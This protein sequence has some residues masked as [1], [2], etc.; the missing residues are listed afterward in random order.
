MQWVCFTDLPLLTLSFA[1]FVFY[2]LASRFLASH[3]CTHMY[4]LIMKV[5]VGIC[6]TLC[7]SNHLYLCTLLSSIFCVFV[8]LSLTMQ[9][10]IIVK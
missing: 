10:V 8:D 7:P 1:L 5:C 2:F 3:L 9:P 4:L 6:V